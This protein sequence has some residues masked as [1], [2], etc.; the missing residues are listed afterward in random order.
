M[1]SEIID[2]VNGLDELEAI[3]DW[4][5]EKAWK[6]AVAREIATCELLLAA[7]GE[8]DPNS[9]R[10]LLHLFSSPTNEKRLRDSIAQLDAGQGFE[11]DLIEP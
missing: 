6:E 2:L 9:D 11:R 7:L 1:R 10:P 8:P 4:S 3:G 5:G